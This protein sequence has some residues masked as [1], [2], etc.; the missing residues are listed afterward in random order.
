MS[1]R[2]CVPKKY[3]INGKGV[4][5]RPV[6]FVLTMEIGRFSWIASFSALLFNIFV[7]SIIYEAVK[8]ASWL[9]AFFMNSFLSTKS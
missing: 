4:N 5:L 2:D 1:S 9:N 8:I 3:N 7:V 6:L